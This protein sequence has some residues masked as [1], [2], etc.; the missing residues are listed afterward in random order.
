MSISG[1][2]RIGTKAKHHLKGL[3]NELKPSI[4]DDIMFAFPTKIT[5]FSS[6]MTDRSWRKVES[7]NAENS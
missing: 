5:D 3:S 7:E 1:C 4:A 2:G 6:I